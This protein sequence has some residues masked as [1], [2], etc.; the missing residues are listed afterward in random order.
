MF[1]EPVTALGA[2]APAGSEQVPALKGCT[3]ERTG[4]VHLT[5]SS[6]SVMGLWEEALGLEALFWGEGASRGWTI[7]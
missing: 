6:G 5:V 2:E 4:Q 1:V 3:V 7:L